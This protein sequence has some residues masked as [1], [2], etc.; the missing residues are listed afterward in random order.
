MSEKP[1][2]QDKR[3][4]L[5]SKELVIFQMQ[6]TKDGDLERNENIINNS[7]KMSVNVRQ[8]KSVLYTDIDFTQTFKNLRSL[9]LYSN[10][11]KTELERNFE[12]IDNKIIGFKERFIKLKNRIDK[13]KM[14]EN[15]IKNKK[16]NQK[17]NLNSLDQI[18]NL[19]SNLQNLYNFHYLKDQVNDEDKLKGLV[20]VI[21]KNDFD[22]SR[23]SK[24]IEIEL[25][26][27]KFKE[28]EK[29]DKLVK[30]KFEELLKYYIEINN[31]I[32]LENLSEKFQYP[33]QIFKF[34]LKIKQDIEKKLKTKNQITM[35]NELDEL[36]E[37]FKEIKKNLEEKQINFFG[38]DSIFGVPEIEH[39]NRVIDYYDK[40]HVSLNI[41]QST[42]FYVN[43]LI[44]LEQELTKISCIDFDQ[45]IEEF[46]K[47][48]DQN[49]VVIK[50]VKDKLQGDFFKAMN[51][52]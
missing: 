5:Q 2:K 33:F 36:L 11:Y 30:K 47:I 13:K 6:G 28:E 43:N 35:K 42:I 37:N 34:C 49:D 24:K 17:Q 52:I 7:K 10:L 8:H 51:Q 40:Y 18:D 16:D 15:I 4:S 41:M 21:Q 46:E 31:A 20:K 29:L 9:D 22:E 39:I 25:Y 38:K 50:Q 27:E 14:T 19:K 3:I 12:K 32:G 44:K 26:Q 23:K 45:K 1:K 48:L